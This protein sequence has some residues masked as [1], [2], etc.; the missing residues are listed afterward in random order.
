MG[1]LSNRFQDNVFFTKTDDII[2][3]SRKS[4]LWPQTFG[5]ACCA[6]ERISAGCSRYD[7]DR[8]GVVNPAT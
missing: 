3:W 4:S 5:I 7:L 6:I 1:V 2:N 8:F